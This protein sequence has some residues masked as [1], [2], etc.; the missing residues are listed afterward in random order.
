LA[1]VMTTLKQVADRAGVSSATVSKVLSN[2][3]YVSADT[4][5]RVLKAVEELGYVPNLAAR[6]L[7]RGRTYN[8]GVIFPLIYTSIFTDPQTLSILEGV[9]TVINER[10]YNILITTPKMPVQQSDQYRRLVQ[11][12]YCDGLILL[13]NLPD[14]LMSSFVASHNYPFVAI[15]YQSLE[16]KSN[17]IRIDDYH[18]AYQAAKHLADLGHRNIGIIAVG[19]VSMFSIS[20]RLRGYRDALASAGI[21][22]D[23]LPVACG[24]FSIESGAQALRQLLKADPRPTA[25]L[26]VTDLMSLGAINAAKSA[27]LNVPR[28]LSIVGFDDIPLAIHIDPPLTTVRQPSR[29]LGET[30]ANLLLDILEKKQ[31]TFD[32]VVLPTQLILRGSTAPVRSA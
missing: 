27:G 9:E 3:P 26:C 7:A 24:S 13:E 15:G 25:V 10:G 22:F 5:A 11:S 21:D 4:R 20:E 14:E 2:T 12:R 18:G 8:I 28:D 23:R 17:T 29:Q 32:P 30:A 6:A 19:P 31:T 1:Y 16:D